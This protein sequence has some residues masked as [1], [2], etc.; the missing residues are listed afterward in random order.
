MSKKQMAED[1]LGKMVALAKRLSGLDPKAEGYE[2]DRSAILEA[3]A[4]LDEDARAAFD[5]YAA[6]EAGEAVDL[7]AAAE[8]SIDG[9]TRAADE[10][11]RA[12]LVASGTNPSEFVAQAQAMLAGKQ[13]RRAAL[14]LAVAKDKGARVMPDLERAVEAALDES[15]P[16]RSL[17]VQYEQDLAKEA[18]DFAVSRIRVLAITTGVTPDGRAGDGSVEARASASSTAKMAQFFVAQKRGEAYHPADYDLAT[19]DAGPAPGA[20]AELARA[21]ASEAAR[22]RAVALAADPSAA[23]T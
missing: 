11:E 2:S 3:V 22:K 16:K 23:L 17:A 14:M 21:R 6:E 12:R 4:F 19:G 10:L 13:P 7:R 8:A 5:A 20:G 18:D 1:A 9:A 15:D